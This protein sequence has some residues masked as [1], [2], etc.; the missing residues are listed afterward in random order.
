MRYEIPSA[1]AAGLNLMRAPDEW[2]MSRDDK[3]EPQLVIN[4]NDTKRNKAASERETNSVR[5]ANYRGR[6]HTKRSTCHAFITPSS[7]KYLC[8]EF[9]LFALPFMLFA[10]G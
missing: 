1:R 2:T 5:G 10:A 4:K 7:S 8:G 3:I 9:L 6:A